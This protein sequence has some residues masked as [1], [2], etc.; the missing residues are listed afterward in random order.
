MEELKQ[1]IFKNMS[2]R[3]KIMIASLVFVLIGLY[4]LLTKISI[5]IGMVIAVLGILTFIGGLSA[6]KTD[7]KEIEN[8]KNKGILDDVCK[9][10][11]LSESYLGD[12]IRLGESYIFRKKDSRV[13][14]YKDI[15]EVEY[16]RSLDETSEIV[17]TVYGLAVTL[18]NNN[19]QSLY[20][21]RE[22]HLTEA[23]EIIKVM[24][25]HNPDIIVK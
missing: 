17:R 3:L 9:D 19:Y 2:D 7:N 4:C 1:Y 12:D 21:Q 18:K 10:F 8:L 11:A 15:K 14:A 24:K 13:I 25:L 22:D 23:N 6:N 5:I 16:R 20:V